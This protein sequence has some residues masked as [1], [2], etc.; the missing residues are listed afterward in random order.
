L[1]DSWAWWLKFERQHGTAVRRFVAI[2]CFIRWLNTP[3]QEH[4]RDVMDKCAAAEP[5]HSPV[6]QSVAKDLQNT[7]KSTKQILELVVEAL[8]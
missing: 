1:G 8:E 5:H 6:W 4:Q 3:S 7:G 2:S